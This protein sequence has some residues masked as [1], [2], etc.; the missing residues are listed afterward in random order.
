M[1]PVIVGDLTY[2]SSLNM[3]SV[4]VHAFKFADKLQVTFYS[5]QLYMIVT[6]R[7]VS[8]FISMSSDTVF[9]S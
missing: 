6:N 2:S 8:G 1:D 9:E 3:A 7:M 4:E 5:L